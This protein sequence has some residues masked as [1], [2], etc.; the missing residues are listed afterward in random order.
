MHGIRVLPVL[1]CQLCGGSL[2]MLKPTIYEALALKLGRIPTNA[3]IKAD[4]ER[5]KTEVLIELAS[6]GKLRFQRR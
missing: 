1:G 3:E 6:K 5:I 4:V 2:I